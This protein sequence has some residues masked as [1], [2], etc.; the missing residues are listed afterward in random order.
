VQVSRR[1]EPGAARLRAV[2]G[3]LEALPGQ[4]HQVQWGDNLVYKVGGKMFA[5]LSR[6]EGVANVS[7]KADDDDFRALSR[8]PGL[9]PA[10]YLA[11]AK[12]VMATDLN[13]FPLKDLRAWLREAYAIVRARLPAAERER[14][15]G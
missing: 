4:T 12:W 2:R 14:L 8:R 11:R 9:R 5:V 1:R 7:F 13:R 10:P 6:E 15:G 3:I